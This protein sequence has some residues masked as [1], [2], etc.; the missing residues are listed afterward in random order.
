MKFIVNSKK[1][2]A[3]EDAGILYLVLFHLDGKDLVK[4]G[5]TTRKIEDRIS[6]ILVS[7]FKVYRVFPYTRPKRFKQTTNILEKE[8]CLHN[9][10]KKYNYKPAKVFSGSTEFFDIPLEAAVIAY[11]RLL[12]GESLS[13]GGYG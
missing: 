9:Y 3:D 12:A 4:I 13:E 11:E 6:E 10:F 7:I 1:E 8:A 2:I 5:I